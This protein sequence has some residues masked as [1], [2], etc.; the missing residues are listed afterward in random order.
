MILNIF[1]ELIKDEYIS[2]IPPKSTGREKYSVEE[3]EKLSAKYNFD[4]YAKED[5]IA[6]ITEFTVYSVVYN[7]KTFIKDIDMIIVGGGGSHNH[8]I[9]KRLKEEFGDIVYSQ[10]ELGYSSDA[11]EAIAF[12]VLGYL[13]L[14]GMSGNVKNATGAKFS[15]VLGNITAVRGEN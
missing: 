5:V 10:D 8:Y 3:L 6:T 1:N 12:V 4:S 13:S 11:K 15:A 14:C 7:Y 2:K 9:M